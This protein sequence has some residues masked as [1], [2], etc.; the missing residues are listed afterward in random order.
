MLPA[1]VILIVGLLTVATGPAVG[2][3]A[4]A[5]ATLAPGATPTAGTT[6]TARA[7]TPPT[8]PTRPAALA[9][10]PGSLAAEARAILG[11]DQGVYVEAANGQV[12]LAQAQARPVHPASVSKVPTTLALLRK[13]G[14]EYRF[15]TTFSTDG[16]VVGDV[17]TGDLL[18]ESSGNPSLVDED[19][20]L[21]ADR[22]IEMGIRQ[23]AGDLKLRGTLIFDWQPDDDGTRLRSALSGSISPAALA[24]VRA[25]ELANASGSSVPDPSGLRAQGIRFVRA[26]P[27]P[28][29]GTGR[30]GLPAPQSGGGAAARSEERRVGKECRSRWSPYH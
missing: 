10:K 20:L 25:F 7:A 18:V 28:P 16:R 14:P 11:P 26:D 9:A 1:V 30:N 8:L 2:A 19:A 5:G 27:R 15:V 17:L 12:L 4:A 23:I 21:V 29:S 24:S 3:T 6:P 13:L 22:M